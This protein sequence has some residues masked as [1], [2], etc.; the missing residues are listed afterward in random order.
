MTWGGFM[1][2]HS[3]DGGW[4]PPPSTL[5]AHRSIAGNHEAL[6]SMSDAGLEQLASR[7]A[8]EILAAALTD[9]TP[10][11]RRGFTGMSSANPPFFLIYL[12]LRIPEARRVSITGHGR[13]GVGLVDRR[14][15]SLAVV[16][17]RSPWGCDS[18]NPRRRVQW[19][20]QAYGGAAAADELEQLVSDWQ[21][22]R[23][24]RQTQ[25][26]IT[27]NRVKDTLAL[28]FAWANG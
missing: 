27:A 21:Q 9:H 20:L 5:S 23:V 19:R 17:L 7:A 28:A 26:E 1:P 13:L 3:G 4:R 8:R 16:T 14:S 12:M 22:L 2:L 24:K 6:I 15:R 18:S 25:L 11:R 10:P